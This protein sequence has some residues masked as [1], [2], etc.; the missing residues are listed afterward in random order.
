VKSLIRIALGLGIVIAM[1]VSALLLTREPRIWRSNI[2]YRVLTDEKVVALTFDDGP[3]PK[4]TPE[5]LDILDKY[6]IRATFFM[7]G[8]EMAKYPTVVSEVVRR[9]HV[10]GNH[11]YSHPHNIELDTRAQ[12]VREVERCEQAIEKLTGKRTHLFRPPRGLIDGTVFSVANDEGYRV[13]LWTVSADHHDAPTPQLMARRVLRHIRPG[14]IILAH[15][16]MYCT[17]RK[18]VK[19]TPLIIK[20][21]IRQGYRFVTIPELIKIGGQSYD[22]GR[23]KSVRLTMAKYSVSPSGTQPNRE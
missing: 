9:G 14:G 16:G 5:I 11:T 13:V 22:P 15:D 19:A 8:K 4:F 21:L 1:V 20:E 18:D 17:R 7:V 6:H 3:H 12:V 2:L 23:A 10:I